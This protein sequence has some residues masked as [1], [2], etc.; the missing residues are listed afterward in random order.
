MN[1]H[2]GAEHN[3]VRKNNSLPNYNE[4]VKSEK[5]YE[6]VKGMAENSNENACTQADNLTHIDNRSFLNVS[7]QAF[8]SSLAGKLYNN[9]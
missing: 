5:R 3:L 8:Q 1:D 4:A 9:N 2:N 6:G 7:P